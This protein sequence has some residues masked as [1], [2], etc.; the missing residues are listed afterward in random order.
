MEFLEIPISVL[1]NLE[2]KKMEMKMKGAEE[3]QKIIKEKVKLNNIQYIRTI[4][5]NFGK[6]YLSQINQSQRIGGLIAYQ[7][8][9]MC[10]SENTQLS[11]QLVE[12][13]IMPIIL[14]QRDND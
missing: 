13:I 7:A 8:I 4:L 10:V 12:T 6:N 3:L 2:N 9:G 14:C 1:K 5:D 11:E